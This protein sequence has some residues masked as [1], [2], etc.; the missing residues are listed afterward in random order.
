MSIEINKEQRAYLVAL[1][2]KMRKK[3]MARGLLQRELAVMAGTSVHAVWALENGVNV[4]HW[5]VVKVRHVLKYGT[6]ITLKQTAID[7]SRPL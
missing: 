7:P 6:Q 5:T 4:T 1:G 2:Q 3:R